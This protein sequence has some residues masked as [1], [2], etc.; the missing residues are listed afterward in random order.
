MTDTKTDYPATCAV[1]CPSGPTNACDE[2]A[3][4]VESL[5]RLMGARTVRTPVPEGAQ[6]DN[7]VN[8]AK[9]RDAA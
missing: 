2:H 4:A 9:N 6:C 8:E 3:H 1:H 5:M 7:C